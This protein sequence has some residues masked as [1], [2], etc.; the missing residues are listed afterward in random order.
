M[1]KTEKIGA[2]R[3][4]R[5]GGEVDKSTDIKKK[6]EYTHKE[7]KMTQSFTSRQIM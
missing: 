3:D 2:E 5:S 4:V 6:H 1:R 7:G